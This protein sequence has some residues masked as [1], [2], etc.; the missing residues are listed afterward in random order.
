[1]ADLTG[2]TDDELVYSALTSALL[3]ITIGQE[4]GTMGDDPRVAEL[5]PLRVAMLRSL[6]MRLHAGEA[7]EIRLPEQ[8]RPS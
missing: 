4:L 1:M 5:A 3:T 6:L 8:L 7:V 2:T